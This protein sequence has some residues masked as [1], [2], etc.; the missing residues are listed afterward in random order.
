MKDY[1]EFEHAYKEK[2][3]KLG[4]QE[5]K[6]IRDKDRSK[7]K[8]TDQ[9]KLC[10]A[11]TCEGKR[12]RVLS[13]TPTEILVDLEEK[14]TACTLRGVLKKEKGK[15]KRLLAIGDFVIVDERGQIAKIEERYS[16]LVR[17]DNLRR[18]LAHVIAANI[19]QV[20]I[21]TSVQEPSLKPSLIDRYI[22]SAIRGNMTPVLLINKIDLA[23]D[24]QSLKELVKIYETL[25]IPVIQVCAT[26]KKG[27]RHVAKIMQGKASVFSGQSGVGKTT[28]INLITGNAF[29]TS[30]VVARTEKGVHTTTK[31]HLIRIGEDS[32]CIDTP[33][34]KSFSL[35]DITSDELSHYFSDLQQ[36][37]SACKFMNCTHTHEPDCRVKEAVQEGLISEI[38]YNSY[39]TIRQGNDEDQKNHWE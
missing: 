25:K 3:N 16:Q 18:R 32:F 9:K 20:L 24:K 14:P 17:R 37:C 19:D 12:G 10:H 36:F 27:L 4:K 5:K 6:R 26:K 29:L 8:T 1:S 33:G 35:W 23:T 21:V 28:L 2:Y 11:S 15:E 39:I 7:H 34:I 38:R 30:D 31:A 22:I 13:I